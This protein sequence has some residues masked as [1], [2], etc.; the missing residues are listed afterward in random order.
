MDRLACLMAKEVIKENCDS[1]VVVLERNELQG[2]LGRMHVGQIIR[3][4]DSICEIMEE[5]LRLGTDTRLTMTS[6][7]FKEYGMGTARGPDGEI[8]M[9]QLFRG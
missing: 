9:V 2:V 1:T 5:C 7:W 8:I 6:M 4:G 3:Q